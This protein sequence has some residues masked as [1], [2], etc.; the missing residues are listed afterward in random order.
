MVDV[1]GKPTTRRVATARG[2]VRL[3]AAAFSALA[4]GRLSKGDAL[5]VARL[6]GIQAA[7][8]TYELV[9]HAHR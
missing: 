5:A 4:E 2:I 3:N 7:K 8:R 1:G 6:A 9:P